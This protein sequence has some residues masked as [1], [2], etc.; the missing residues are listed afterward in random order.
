MSGVMTHSLRSKG[1]TPN[2]KAWFPPN[3]QLTH[4][5]CV[6]CDATDGGDT[7][8]AAQASDAAAKRTDGNGL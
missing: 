3:W 5:S 1:L 6:L 2:P 7:T 8:N 4:G